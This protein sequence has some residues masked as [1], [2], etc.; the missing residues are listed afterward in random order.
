M[1]SARAMVR[2]SVDPAPCAAG[3]RVTVFRGTCAAFAMAVESDAMMCGG[4][5]STMWLVVSRQV[6]SYLWGG[7]EGGGEGG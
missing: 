3:M 6:I 2:E 5:S 1:W 7:G 4:K